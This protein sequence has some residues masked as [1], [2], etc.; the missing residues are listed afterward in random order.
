MSMNAGRSSSRTLTR[1]RIL[2]LVGA[3][4]IVL[5]VVMATIAYAKSG[6][7]A[8]P[9][10]PTGIA[11]WAGMMDIEWN[12]VDGAE[13]Y[14]VQYFNVSGWA[15]LP[16]NGIEI[17]FYG[18]GAVVSGLRHSNSYTFRVR[19]V[20]SRGASEWSDFGWVRQTD[21]P[22]AWKDV[23]KPANVAATGAPTINGTS[24]VGKTLTADTSGISDQNG[25]DRVRFH[26]QWMRSDGTADTDITGA[27]RS[28]HT[29]TGYDAGSA[30]KVRVSFTDRQGFPEALT[31]AS[32]EVVGTTIPGVPRS[33]EVS[34]AGTGEL[35]ASWVEPESDGGSPITGYTVQ[36]KESSDSWDS[37]TDVLAAATTATATSHT[38]TNLS[39]DTEYAVRVFA[40]NSVGNG[41]PSGEVTVTA[42][43]MTSE[44]QEAEQTSDPAVSGPAEIEYAENG[45]EMVATYTASGLA[46]GSVTW[47]VS[48]LSRSQTVCCSSRTSPTMRS[49]RMTT[50]TMCM[51]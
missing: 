2:G 10:Q 44:Q 1:S 36:W 15:D 27:T 9:D 21:S 24:V 47:S 33:V 22:A 26:Y 42:E 25:L 29:L 43:A 49:H 8:R 32:T 46:D 6:V 34:P 31:S 39:L 14:E 20:N 40:T 50:I 13:T 4:L 45:E 11:I 51:R 37:S 16:G 41:S 19:A 48:G 3:V 17:A 30:L 18:A 23:P 35:T 12:E 7:P 38:V 5:C 28:S